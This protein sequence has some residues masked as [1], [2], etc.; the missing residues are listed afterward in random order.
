VKILAPLL[1]VALA[2]CAA[3]RSEPQYLE[4]PEIPEITF[5]LCET[6]VTNIQL[7][8]ISENDAQVLLTWVE[9]VKMFRDRRERL[10]RDP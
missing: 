10:L 7:I 2:G 3:I 1:I 4:F 6:P 5:L 8:C 9:K